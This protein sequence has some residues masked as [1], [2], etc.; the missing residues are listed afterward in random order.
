MPWRAA[1]AASPEQAA[2]L[3]SA[4]LALWTGEPWTPGDGYDWFEKALRDDQ[5]TAVRLGGV[6]AGATVAETTSAIPAPLTGLIGRT[7]E[8]AAV[9]AA[10]ARSRL[11]TII[12]PGGAGKTRIAVEVARRTPGALLVELAPVA[13]DEVWAGADRR[14]GTRACA[15]PT[16]RPAPATPRDGWSPR[17]PGA[18][19]CS[20]STTA[21]TS[22]RR[23][24]RWRTTC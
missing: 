19:R 4:A 22:S 17:W 16:A 9:A 2:G 11:T 15:P 5:A 20:C 10:V 23:P 8:L 3:A 14:A 7:E 1:S 6:A 24:R 21:S 12:G 18:T 13:A